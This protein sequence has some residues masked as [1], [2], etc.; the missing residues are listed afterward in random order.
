MDVAAGHLPLVLRTGRNAESVHSHDQAG[1]DEVEGLEGTIRLLGENQRDILQRAFAVAESA[2]A[3]IG[4]YE[5]GAYGHS[6]YQQHTA[7]E[8]RSDGAETSAIAARQ[9]ICNSHGSPRLELGAR[10]RNTAAL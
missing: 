1:L 8:E 2:L 9:G 7:H 10:A 4:E 3:K 6:R 5:S